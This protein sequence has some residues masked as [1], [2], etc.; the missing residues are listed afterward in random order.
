MKKNAN[1]ITSAFLALVMV[2]ISVFGMS[3]TAFA[4]SN[5]ESADTQIET[6]SG[7]CYPGSNYLGTFTF[8]DNNTGSNRT[9]Y[10]NRMRFCIAHKAGDNN[11]YVYNLYVACIRWDGVNMKAVN[12]QNYGTP[13]ENGYYFYVSDW[14][15]VSYG[16]DYHLYY[17]ANTF[18]YGHEPRTVNIHA[19]LDVE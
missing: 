15:N 18:A 7:A 6:R 4:E 12:L 10:G 16:V 14:F 9:I 19:W 17:L 1:R 2:C 5:V 13:D 3:V 11:P 8:N